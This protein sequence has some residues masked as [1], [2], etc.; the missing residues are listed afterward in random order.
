M[1]SPNELSPNGHASATEGNNSR[2]K[3]VKKQADGD[4]MHVHME[5]PVLLT[6]MMIV[7]MQVQCN[8]SV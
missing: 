2:E 7:E 5:V 3:V 8:G 6:V 4:K 1:L